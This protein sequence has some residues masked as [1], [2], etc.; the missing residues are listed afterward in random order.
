MTN[1]AADT[2]QVKVVGPVS[3]SAQSHPFGAA[4][5]TRAP[6]DLRAI[7]YVE[8]EYFVSGV[9]NVYDWPIA[10]PASVRTA[11]APYTTR[12]LIRRPAKLALDRERVGLGHPS[13]SRALAAKR[14]R[15]EPV[16][17]AHP[18]RTAS[19]YSVTP[20]MNFFANAA[21]AV[22]H[23]AERS[24]NRFSR[25]IHGQRTYQGH[26]PGGA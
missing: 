1:A 18:R 10:G 7:G 3:V 2:P 24:S 23:S 25:G 6:Q 8:E 17:R 16:P 11:N 26:E 20:A 13:A 14:R 22:R 12:V 19:R 5:H 4:D 15:P 9:A 21:P